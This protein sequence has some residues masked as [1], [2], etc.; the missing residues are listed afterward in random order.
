V[1]FSVSSFSQ[2]LY[3]CEDVDSDGYPV[4]ESDVFTIPDAGGYLYVLVRLPYEV[5]C[6]SVSFEIDRN[7]KYDNTI[8]LDTEKDWVWFYKKIEFYKAGTYDFYVYDCFS[9]K[10]ADGSVR[11]KYR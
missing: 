5:L 10:L 7:G 6:N 8:Y 2:T 11:I 9:Y 1:I 4:N 3:F